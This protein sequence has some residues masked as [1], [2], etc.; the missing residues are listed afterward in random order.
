MTAPFPCPSAPPI[1]GTQGISYIHTTNSRIN[2]STLEET[3]RRITP[4]FPYT[5]DLCPLHTLPG[6]SFP[7]HWHKEIE[8][9]Y[10]RRGTLEYIL[11]DG[12]HTFRQGE[13]GFLNSGVLHMTC[14]PKNETCLQEEHLFL[15]SF[16]G[17]GDSTIL[18]ARYIA[19]IVER[20]D[21]ELYRF[22]PAV[23]DHQTI[24][25]LMKASFD[26][27]EAAQEG[28]EFEIREYMSRIWRILFSLTKDFQGNTKKRPRNDRIK[29][30]MEFIA[31]HYHEKLTL[32]Q[33][34]DSAF[35]SPR[36]CSRCFQEVLGQPPFLYLTD[37]R[38]HKAC[39]LLTHTSLSIT[40]ISTACGFNSSS[41]FAQAFHKA[42]GCTPKQ[43]RRQ[44]RPSVSF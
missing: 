29:L 11:P 22:D 3:L 27:Y 23:S 25:R 32:K 35:I 37:Y 16:L 18:T 8:I 5:A 19:P 1:A 38:L 44:D 42:F 7:W 24:I 21:M 41:Y 39:S 15:P 13:G 31:A 28:Y 17:G 43:Y 30:M 4:D 36:E 9:F 14:C 34:A 20:P 6:S 2:T 10:M 40:Q 33:I 26:C 12:P